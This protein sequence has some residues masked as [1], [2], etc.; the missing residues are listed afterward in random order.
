MKT[1]VMACALA[2]VALPLQANT[3]RNAC[4]KA[5]R[6]G[7]VRT[8]TCIQQ[9]ADRTLSNQ[10]QRLAASFFSDPDKSEEI[11]MSD[12]RQHEVFWERYRAFG[13]MAEA[14]CS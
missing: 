7:D 11:R 6:A 4:L 14:F 1:I 9:A 8:C 13:A 2:C 10:D 12:R 3:I 5:E